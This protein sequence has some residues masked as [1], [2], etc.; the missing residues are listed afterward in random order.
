MAIKDH[1]LQENKVWHSGEKCLLPLKTA[2]LK[3]SDLQDILNLQSI[4][5]ETMQNK[6]WC[7]KLSENDFISLLQD[8]GIILG[9]KV[10]R[11][12]IGFYGVFFPGNDPENL[13]NDLGLPPEEHGNICHLEIAYVHPHYRG[14]GL[15]LFLGKAVIKAARE[16]RGFRYLCG[17]VEPANIVAL[18]NAMHF[19]LQIVKLKEKYGGLRRFILFCDFDEDFNRLKGEPVR[20]DY[21]DISAQQKLLDTGYRGVAAGR[22]E[23]S[24]YIDYLRGVL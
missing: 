16:R 11:E 4:V 23:D 6:S 8:K 2:F 19:G 12:L 15:Q 20:V 14:N 7:S 10:N 18:N 1:L 13:G 22:Q 21:K 9:A 5:Y 3:I 17:T 24:Y